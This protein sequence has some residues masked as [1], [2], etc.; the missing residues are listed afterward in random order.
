M[1]CGRDSHN[2]VIAVLNEQ[3]NSLDISVVDIHR[4]VESG[5]ALGGTKIEMLTD[6]PEDIQKIWDT[7]FEGFTGS[8]IEPKV[9][10]SNKMTK[11]LN[12]TFLA[13]YNDIEYVLITINPMEQR[14]DFERV[15]DKGVNDK[16]TF[17][18]AFT[19]LK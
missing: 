15:F 17:G 13:V 7:Q 19:W 2:A 9:Y 4:I 14:A 18:Y 10:L 5:G 16:A 8:K 1:F 6:I 12:Y 11:G 3:P